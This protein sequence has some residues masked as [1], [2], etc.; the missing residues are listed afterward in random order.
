MGQLYGDGTTPKRPKSLKTKTPKG[1]ISVSEETE[2][3]QSA[4]AQEA[5]KK[6]RPLPAVPKKTTMGTKF[7]P[8]VSFEDILNEEAVANATAK[9][10]IENASDAST[11]AAAAAEHAAED[12][13]EES[14]IIPDA[15][16]LVSPTGSS[17]QCLVLCPVGD[18]LVS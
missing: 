3:G 18:R 4:Q 15:V 13:L 14:D 5:L 1:G 6:N 9:S 2:T 12:S 17:E 7:S 11:A 16:D 8:N 10:N